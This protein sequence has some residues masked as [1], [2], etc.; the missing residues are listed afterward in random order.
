MLTNDFHVDLKIFFFGKESFCFA[1]NNTDI[2][3]SLA[4]E[5]FSETLY[6]SE[7]TFGYSKPCFHFI[8]QGVDVISH[9]VLALKNYIVEYASLLALLKV[10]L[11]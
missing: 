11:N 4:V 3:A 10:V 9:N 6:P 8:L 7:T 5:I 2:V 1:R